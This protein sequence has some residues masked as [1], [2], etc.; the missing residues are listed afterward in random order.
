MNLAKVVDSI[1]Q[2]FYNFIWFSISAYTVY[3]K[4]EL[5]KS[6]NIFE[7]L[8]TTVF[9]IADLSVFSSDTLK[10]FF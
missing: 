3:Y 1:V 5:L 6:L 4:I 2:I 9:F 10:F 8:S 7:D